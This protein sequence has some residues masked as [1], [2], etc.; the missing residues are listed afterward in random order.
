[1]SYLQKRLEQQNQTTQTQYF[2]RFKGKPF[3]LW[4]LERHQNEFSRTNGKCCF[5]HV[6]GLPQKNNQPRPLYQFQRELVSALQS[7]DKK[8]IACVK[9]RGTGL[10]EIACRFMCYL[11]TRDKQMQNKNMVILTGIRENLSEELLHRFR[12]LLPDYQ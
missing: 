4:D 9:A 8:L 5:N 3:W 6:V 10:S 12:N 1:M 11:C 2:D 7:D